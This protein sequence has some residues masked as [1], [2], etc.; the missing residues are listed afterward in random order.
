MEELNV[1]KA[2]IDLGMSGILLYFLYIIW[3]DRKTTIYEK[4]NR[5]NE[6]SDE[7]VNIVRDN[8]KVQEELKANIKE[9]TKATETLTNYIYEAL[10]K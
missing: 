9:N 1:V 4:D 8:T 5:I 2:I 6:L 3:N 10:K 7:V